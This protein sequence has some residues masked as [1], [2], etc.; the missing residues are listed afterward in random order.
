MTG[1]NIET[2]GE[3]SV[4]GTAEHNGVL[5]LAVEE[6]SPADRIGLQPDDVITEIRGET[7][8]NIDTLRNIPAPFSGEVTVLRKQQKRILK[9]SSVQ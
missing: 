9:E 8:R 5:V 1:K 3:M 7:V 4:Y 6:N 2:D